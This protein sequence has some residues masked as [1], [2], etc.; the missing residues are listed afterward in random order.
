MLE[1]KAVVAKIIETGK[2]MAILEGY[3]NPS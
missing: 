1:E 3:A 2:G